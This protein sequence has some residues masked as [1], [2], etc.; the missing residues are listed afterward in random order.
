MVDRDSAVLRLPDYVE[1]Q[2]PLDADHSTMVKFNDRNSPGY[3]IV[4]ESLR[5][6]EKDAVRVV[7]DRTGTHPSSFHFLSRRFFLH[8]KTVSHFF[9]YG[10][11]H[12]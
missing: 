8:K 12:E 3:G 11:L 7:A 6:F 2:L 4:L 9:I 5:Q 10:A 1:L